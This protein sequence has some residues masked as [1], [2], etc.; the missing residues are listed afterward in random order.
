MCPLPEVSS[1]SLLARTTS[2][3]YAE[4]NHGPEEDANDRVCNFWSFVA[5]WYLVLLLQKPSP[6]TSEH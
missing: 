5:L 2:Y 4:T 1:C 3:I 6:P